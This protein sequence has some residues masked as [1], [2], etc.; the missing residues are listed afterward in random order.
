MDTDMY[1]LLFDDSMHADTRTDISYDETIIYIIF[2]M[3][4]ICIAML[5]LEHDAGQR[6]EQHEEQ[7]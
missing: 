1:M 3:L 5:G 4:F 7:L 2:I 6:Q